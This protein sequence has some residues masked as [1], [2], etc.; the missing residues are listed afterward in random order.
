MFLSH[1]TQS[2]FLSAHLQGDGAISAIIAG[3][4]HESVDD[5]C[6]VE[7]GGAECVSTR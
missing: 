7:K 3:L 4:H 5:L 1:K 6:S 2:S